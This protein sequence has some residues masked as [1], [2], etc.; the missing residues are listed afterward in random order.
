MKLK[1]ECNAKNDH[2]RFQQPFEFFE[3]YTIVKFNE[4]TFA[5]LQKKIKRLLWLDKL[6][7]IDPK[8]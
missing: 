3:V 5:E 8:A 6:N 7:I 4:L 1:I 2:Q